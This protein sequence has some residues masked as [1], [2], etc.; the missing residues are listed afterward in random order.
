MKKRINKPKRPSHLKTMMD[1]FGGMD[2]VN[3]RPPVE[4]Q[5]DAIRTFRDIAMGNLNTE[6]EGQLFLNPHFLEN[7]IIACNTKL[8]MHFTHY[9]A[10]IAAI[11][12]GVFGQ[13]SQ[14][15]VD[16]DMRSYQVYTIIYDNLMCLK[17]TGDLNYISYMQQQINQNRLK[18]NI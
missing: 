2:Y 13:E 3:L 14:D 17:Q 5:K 8:R 1:K 7:A 12:T 18:Y 11:Q 16:N 4:I 6:Y 9:K 10:G 15:I